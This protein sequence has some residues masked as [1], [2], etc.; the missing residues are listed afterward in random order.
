ME[1]TLNFNVDIPADD[2]S[3]FKMLVSKMG[4]RTETKESII[5]KLFAS[6]P[7][8]VDITDEEIMEEVRS[9]RYGK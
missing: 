4:W 9:V 1:A 6:C 5:A 2:M 7:E 3:F 8:N